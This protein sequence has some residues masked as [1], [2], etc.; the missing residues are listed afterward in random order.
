MHST[1]PTKSW[2]RIKYFVFAMIATMATYVLLHNERFLVE[3]QNPAWQHYESIGWWLLAHGLAGACALILVPMQFSD[4]LRARFTRL[5]RVVGRIYV[6]AA[7]VFAPLGAYIQFLN[8]TLVAAPRS[9]TFAG[10]IDAVL[11][12]TTT[13]IGFYFALKRMIPQHRQWMTRSYACALT[14]FEV[15]FII[16]VAGWDITDNAITET[17]VW[18]CVALAVLVGD[19]ANQIYELQSMQ[20][21]TTRPVVQ[22][23]AAE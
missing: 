3:P 1:S 23:V 16:G 19:I 10:T 21:R 2:F 7:L 9:F 11:I 17:V 8:E 15:R 14:F 12:V 22:A 20:S 4:R 6:T 18:V 5:H 13:A